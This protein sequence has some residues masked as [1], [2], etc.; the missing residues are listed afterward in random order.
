MG[1]P[2][3]VGEVIQASEPEFL[4]KSKQKKGNISRIKN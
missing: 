3:K 2:L 4:E 1:Y